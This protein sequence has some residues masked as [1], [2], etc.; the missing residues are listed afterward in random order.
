MP[1]RGSPDGKRVAG[2]P[3]VILDEPAEHLDQATAEALMTD[4]LSTTAGRTVLLITHRLP[5]DAA[6]DEVFRLEDGRLAPVPPADLS[7]LC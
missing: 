3:V 6:V 5:R 4:L 7:P 2:F 1:G